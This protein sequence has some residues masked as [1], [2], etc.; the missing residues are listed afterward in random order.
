[1]SDFDW[2]DSNSDV[3]IQ[4]MRSVAV[5]RSEKSNGVMILQE[6]EMYESDD[7]A[8]VIPDQHVPLLI[9]A[10]QRIIKI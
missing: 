1:M 9:A 8:I 2:S 6:D 4:G 7:R 10:L 5:V 3:V